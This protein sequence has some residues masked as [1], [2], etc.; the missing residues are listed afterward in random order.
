MKVTML[1]SSEGQSKVA[2]LRTGLVLGG[3]GAGIGGLYGLGDRERNFDQR[4]LDS[5]VSNRA[6]QGALTGL[7]AYAGSSIVPSLI[8][9]GRFGGGVLGGIGALLLSDRI[10]EKDKV[11]PF[12]EVQK[13]IGN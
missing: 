5:N 7:G 12:Y 9:I 6:A 8:N 11:D 1:L 3:L 13:W 10:L 4:L 2:S